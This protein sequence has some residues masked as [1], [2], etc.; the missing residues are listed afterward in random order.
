MEKT[1][2]IKLYSIGQK[3][4]QEDQQHSVLKSGK[5]SLATQWSTTALPKF[6][7]TT[8]SIRKPKQKLISSRI[9]E[10]VVK[11]SAAKRRW[12]ATVIAN[13]LADSVKN[14]QH[15]DKV[16]AKKELKDTID[17]LMIEGQKQKQQNKEIQEIQ[18]EIQGQIV[19]YDSMSKAVTKYQPAS[20]VLHRVFPIFSYLYDRIF[21]TLFPVQQCS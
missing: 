21:E 17:S 11:S 7:P 12:K 1:A 10:K 14:V 15:K 16:A 2:I 19:L 4:N 20:R 3:W 6:K 9:A 18:E 13:N 5:K 8:P